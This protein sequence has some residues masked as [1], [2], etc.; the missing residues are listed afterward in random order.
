MNTHLTLPL[1]FKKHF[2][3]P[4][5]NLKSERVSSKSSM[6]TDWLLKL[7]CKLCLSRAIRWVATTEELQVLEDY[8]K[9]S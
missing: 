7:L 9:K 6:K 1:V 8:L 4:S 3:K 2:A 5:L